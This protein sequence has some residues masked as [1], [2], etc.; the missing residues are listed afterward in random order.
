MRR[1]YF[2]PL[3]HTVICRVPALVVD[4]RAVVVEGKL[5]GAEIDVDLFLESEPEVTHDGDV[6]RITRPEYG[7]EFETR[8]R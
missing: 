8:F 2:L 3:G 4:R 1:S 7:D 6:L 5:Q